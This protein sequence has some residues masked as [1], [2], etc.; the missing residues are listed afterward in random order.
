MPDERES[1][2]SPEQHLTDIQE[3][4]SFV[5][6][7]CRCGWR[8]PARRARARAQADATAHEP[9]AQDL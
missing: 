9:L 1:A 8:G 7:H 5:S 2:A 3:R 4:G 6:A